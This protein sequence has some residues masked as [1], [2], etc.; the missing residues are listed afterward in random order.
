MTSRN[1]KRGAPDALAKDQFALIV[2]PPK[3]K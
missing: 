1:V 3:S 2:L